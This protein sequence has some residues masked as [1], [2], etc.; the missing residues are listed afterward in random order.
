MSDK[1]NAVNKIDERR[2]VADEENNRPVKRRRN[3]N[4]GYMN[5]I[6]TES[7][8]ARTAA[9]KIEGHSAKSESL[10][11]GLEALKHRLE[12]LIGETP[13]NDNKIIETL[14]CMEETSVTPELLVSSKASKTVLSLKK[15][16]NTNV[17]SAS[18]RLLAKWKQVFQNSMP[19]SSSSSS[20]NKDTSSSPEKKTENVAPSVVTNKRKSL[21]SSQQQQQQDEV[22]KSSPP[23]PSPSTSVNN[24]ESSPVT[25][26]DSRLIQNTG[27][28]LRDGYRQKLADTLKKASRNV[29]LELEDKDIIDLAVQIEQEVHKTFHFQTTNLFQAKLRSIVFNL[30]DKR[31]PDFGKKVLLR[32]YT[33]EQLAT[34]D[35]KDMASKAKNEERKELK[36]LSI[37]LSKTPKNVQVETGLFRCKRCK[38]N[39]C[40][41]Y[42]MQTRSADEPMTVF[43]TCTVCDNRWRF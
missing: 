29:G 32:I 25:P 43:V 30:G 10:V 13:Q 28:R 8:E 23:S 37:E 40:T 1:Y 12:R 14:E 6:N 39:K 5:A 24:G 36:N 21:P 31:N 42:E 2:R 18:R 16:T 33:P 3:E 34:M 19:S 4:D 26:I 38:Q 17:A 35:S 11:D 15:H 27:D 9:V 22:K 20:A 7:A 41:Y